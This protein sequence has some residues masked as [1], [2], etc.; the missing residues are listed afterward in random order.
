M[1]S[2][3]TRM[4]IFAVACAA[5]FGEAPLRPESSGTN[6][7]T[8]TCLAI[9]SIPPISHS[10]Q[11]EARSLRRRLPAIASMCTSAFPPGLCSAHL[12]YLLGGDRSDGLDCHPGGDDLHG[13]AHRHQCH[14]PSGLY[15]F[16]SGHQHHWSGPV[17]ADRR[18]PGV[19]GF[20]PPLPSGDYTS[21]IQQT[22]PTPP[23]IA[24][25]SSCCR[26][27]RA[28]RCLFLQRPERKFA[29]GAGAC[30]E[31]QSIPMA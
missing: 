5:M 13:A 6:R 28:S 8:A 20:F 25:I 21:W 18:G 17:D 24:S 3:K 31:R 2:S 27:R 7:S 22:S 26:S 30:I 4:V 1:Q 14:Q 9:G 16:R 19:D 23:P 29:G 12:Q 15:A 11:V 10:K